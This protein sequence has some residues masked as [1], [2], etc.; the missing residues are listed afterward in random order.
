MV[1]RFER[2]ADESV[3]GVVSGK[4]V[5]VSCPHVVAKPCVMDAC[6]CYLISCFGQDL[7]TAIILDQ[8]C[9]KMFAYNF[10]AV[11]QSCPFCLDW[12]APH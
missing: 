9:K 6:L 8:L 1:F 3:Y 5:I 10:F 12:K 2:V 11:Q 4:D 7:L